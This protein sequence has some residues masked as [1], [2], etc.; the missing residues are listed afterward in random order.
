MQAI[1][2]HKTGDH[3]VLKIEKLDDPKPKKNEV[4]V[5]HTAIGVNFFDICFRRGQYKIDSMPAVLGFEACGIIES[6]GSEV[7]NFKVGERVAYGTGPIGAYAEKRAINQHYLLAPP[8]SLSD[9]EIA[10]SISKGLMAHTLLHRAYIA[11]RAKK[12]LIHAVAGG[13][14]HITCQ[15]A[16]HLGLEIIGT[17]GDDK[18]IPF[19]SSIG[20]DHVINYKTQNFVDEVAKITNNGGVG[21]VYDGVGKDTLTKSTECLWPMGIC[22]SYGEAS[23]NTEKFDLNQLV[24]NSLYLTRPTLALYKSNRVEL[25]LAAAEIFAALEKKILKPKITTYNFK[26]VKKAHHDLESRATTGSLVLTF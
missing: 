14:G 9:V 5:R 25:T 15:L 2:V 7:T 23:G 22:V 26:D 24:G 3:G 8:A 10:G 4:V 6:I 18:K 13:V 19:A 1:V 17:V 11:K 16:K 12:I 21:L 20:C